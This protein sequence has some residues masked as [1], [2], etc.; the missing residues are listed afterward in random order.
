M[1]NTAETTVAMLR[2]L[3]ASIECGAVRVIDR[4]GEYQGDVAE[5]TLVLEGT[6]L[7]PNACDKPTGAARK[8]TDDTRRTKPTN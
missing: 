2:N 1:D 8:E 4:R 7:P 6:P 5:L 3:I